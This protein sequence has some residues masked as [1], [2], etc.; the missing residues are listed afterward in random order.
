[1]SACGEVEFQQAS[2]AQ[3]IET[4]VIEKLAQANASFTL[5]Q[6]RASALLEQLCI[7]ISQVA[8]GKL[9]EV[10]ALLTKHAEDYKAAH[11]AS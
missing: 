11:A 3:V 5:E 4:A 2:Q 10:P 1:M 7:D 9:A 8:Q 6:A